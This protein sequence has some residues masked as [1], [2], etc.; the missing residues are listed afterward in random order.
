MS[1]EIEG[2]LFIGN[3]KN[4]DVKQKIFTELSKIINN[5]NLSDPV[6]IMPEWEGYKK[7]SPS[8]LKKK[9][10]YRY[11]STIMEIQVKEHSDKIINIKSNDWKI[12]NE[13]ELLNLT[14]V[15]PELLF[16]VIQR[17]NYDYPNE[18]LLSYAKYKNGKQID[19]V[20]IKSFW[21]PFAKI[22]FF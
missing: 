9:E 21:A 5:Y 14:K 19:R 18:S 6:G 13:R 11:L 22:S 4:M 15:Y 12:S 7:V 8:E 16:F 2:N 17:V 10:W 1:K 20:N 3:F